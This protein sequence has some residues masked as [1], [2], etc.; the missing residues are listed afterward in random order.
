[1]GGWTPTSNKLLFGLEKSRDDL[2]GTWCSD[3][4]ARISNLPQDSLPNPLA[5][6][7]LVKPMDSSFTLHNMGESARLWVKTMCEWKYLALN[8]DLFCLELTF[9]WCLTATSYLVIHPSCLDR[10]L[11][12]FFTGK[13]VSWPQCQF[14]NNKSRVLRQRK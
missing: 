10:T 4:P 12:A 13:L 9:T 2:S 1:M 11:L 14:K 3:L 7:A 5:Q 8:T 6:S